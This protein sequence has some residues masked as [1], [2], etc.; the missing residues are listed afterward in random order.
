[1]NWN[2]LKQVAVADL[3]PLKTAI[4][5]TLQNVHKHGNSR[6]RNLVFQKMFTDFPYVHSDGI[7]CLLPKNLHKTPPFRINVYTKMFTSIHS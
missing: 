3:V 4:F 1:M 5:T 2:K 7:S 6:N